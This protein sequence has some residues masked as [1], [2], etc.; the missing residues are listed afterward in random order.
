[1]QK[2]TSSPSECVS[3]I[4]FT[5]MKSGGIGTDDAVDVLGAIML[6]GL[7]R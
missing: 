1:M 5:G 2:L 4:Y 7:D 3:E 6:G